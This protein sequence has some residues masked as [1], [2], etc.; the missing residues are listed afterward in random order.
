MT[1]IW[2]I[3]PSSDIIFSTRL[4]NRKQTV[5]VMHY[6]KNTFHGLDVEPLDGVLV[7]FQVWFR[8]NKSL[9][10]LIHFKGFSYISN[11]IRTHWKWNLKKLKLW[12]WWCEEFQGYVKNFEVMWRILRLINIFMWKTLSQPFQ[13]YASSCRYLA[14]KFEN[15]ITS[16]YQTFSWITNSWTWFSI[17]FNANVAN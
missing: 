2:S 9:L 4:R 16:K 3:M 8:E 17:F 1:I 11:R 15:L 7:K 12:C 13:G 10:I 6:T 14:Y 5:W